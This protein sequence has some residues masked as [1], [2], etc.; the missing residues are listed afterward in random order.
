MGEEITKHQS[1]L[2]YTHI[3]FVTYSPTPSKAH[4]RSCTRAMAHNNAL[5]VVVLVCL[6]SLVYLKASVQFNSSLKFE[7]FGS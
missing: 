6:K 4:L 3:A 1:R 2:Q 5:G 7:S